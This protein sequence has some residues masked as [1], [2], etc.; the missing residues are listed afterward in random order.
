MRAARR[1]WASGVA[2]LTTS[3]VVG[4]VTVYRGATIS[5]FQII[6]LEPAIIGV[7]LERQGATGA[8]VERTGICAISVLDR[9]QEFQADRFAGLGPLPPPDFR[10]V[11][12]AFAVTGAPILTGSLAW[13][14]CRLDQA[15]TVG[16]HLALFCRVERV[17]IAPDSDDPLIS[18]EG[19]FRRVEGIL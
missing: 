2:V 3:E 7:F 4:E 13:F 17:G 1:R 19:S 11:A 8:M 18:Y 12:H 10:G 6:S 16:D 15:L 14:D 9:S 5:G